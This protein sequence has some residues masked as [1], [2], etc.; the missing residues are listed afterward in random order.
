MERVLVVQCA[1][2]VVAALAGLGCGGDPGPPDVTAASARSVAA[3][4]TEVPDQSTEPLTTGW[5]YDPIGK[6]DPYRPYATILFPGG[7]LPLTDLQHWDLDQLQLV[8]ILRQQG[9]RLAMLEDP[10]GR[11][12]IVAV[13]DLVGRR[14]GRITRVDPSCLVVTEVVKDDYGRE[15]PLTHEIP[16]PDPWTEG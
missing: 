5:R 11:G 1:G 12:H 13:G 7:A 15:L 2:W 9:H 3:H 16:L 6:R 4:V 10:D 8:G 14:W